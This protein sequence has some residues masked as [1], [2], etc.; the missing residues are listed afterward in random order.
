MIP[1]DE[2]LTWADTFGSVQDDPPDGDG[3]ALEALAAEVRR[4]RVAHDAEKKWRKDSDEAAAILLEA[5]EEISNLAGWHADDE[6]DPS[7]TSP[8]DPAAHTNGLIRQI[9]KRFL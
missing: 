9:C 8:D 1:L 7:N 5:L 4:L 3:P 6:A 2:A